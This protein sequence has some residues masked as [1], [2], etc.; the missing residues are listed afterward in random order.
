MNDSPGKAR[1][2]YLSAKEAVEL[3]DIRQHTLY[4]YVS[5]GWIGSVKQPGR[6][7]H[8][9]LRSDVER[10][11]ARSL[12]RA[13]H[14]AVAA[15]A[16]HHGE[17]IIPTSITEITADGPRYRGHLA[18]DLVQRRVPFESVAELLWSGVLDEAGAPWEVP[19]PSKALRA[20][21]ASLRSPRAGDQLLEIFALVTLHLGVGHG[22]IADRLRRGQTLQVAREIMRTLVGCCGLASP[23][24]D[25][26]QIRKGQSL[27]QGFL[28][29]FGG[30]DSDQN[31]AAVEAMLILLADHELSPGTLSARV[32]ASSGATLSACIASA[33]C[34]SAGVNV[35]RVFDRVD[36][37]VQG[38]TSLP[39]LLRRAAAFRARAAAI[40]GFMHPLY[41][42]G[43]PR[44]RLLFEMVRRRSPQTR[45]LRAIAHF[46]DACERETGLHARHELAMV[47]LTRAMQ[48]P[49][50]AP[51][52]LFVLGRTAGWVAHVR[53]QRLSG[54]LLR[55]R[56]KFTSAAPGT[57]A[58]APWSD[59][60]DAA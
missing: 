44:A 16:M 17:P 59:T 42:H 36:R 40:P 33:L 27:A 8:L 43:D 39:A 22:A 21:V 18:T 51:S 37:F 5:R 55:P 52:A 34:A 53:E 15:S 13:G 20:L 1:S 31:R 32:C 49:P 10:M 38:A 41:P 14:G 48:L 28:Q 24:G 9:Y 29:A 3:L 11:G 4:A 45:E 47:A 35:G 12:A 26:V 6:K 19:P 30:V 57:Q 56:A 46:V 54:Q 60:L 2:D 7:D 23:R 58:A 50:Q 25:Y